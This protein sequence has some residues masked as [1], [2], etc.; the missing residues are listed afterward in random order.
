MTARMPLL[1]LAAALAFPA[2][3]APEPPVTRAAFASLEKKLDRKIVALN[4]N[5]PFEMLGT[6]RGVYLKGYGAVFTT[7]LSLV[8][9]MISPFMPDLTP[10]DIEKL[11]QKKLAKLGALKQ[12]MRQMLIEAAADLDTVPANEQIVLGVTLFNRSFEIK[13]GL[14]GQVV[15]QAPRQA[16]LDYKAG[17]IKAPALEAL[18]RTQEL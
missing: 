18:I 12:F 6:V 5:D 16:L 4:V 15:M 17:R 3:Q 11:H 7:E 1:A 2:A 10:A 13:D 9:T 14:P 8:V